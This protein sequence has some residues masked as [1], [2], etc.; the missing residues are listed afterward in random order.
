MARPIQDDDVREL[1]QALERQIGARPTATL[2][3]MFPTDYARQGDLMAVQADMVAVQADVAAIKADVEAV[4]A[5]MATKADFREFRS[6]IRE[7]LSEWRFQN[8]EFQ[9]Q[10]VTLMFNLNATIARLVLIIIGAMIGVG[11]IVLAAVK[12]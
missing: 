8:V 9:T 5:D 7:E 11:G 10:V 1:E 12:L 2:M 4:K 6:E 3:A